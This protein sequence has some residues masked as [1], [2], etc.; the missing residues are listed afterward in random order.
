MATS[1]SL[2]LQAVFKTAADR[3]G[4]DTAARIVSGLSPAAKAF[5]VAA[6]A[7]GRPRDVVVL[8]TPTDRDIDQ[9]VSDVAFF[10]AALEGLSESAASRAVLPFPSHEVD[11]YRGLTPHF[12]V[13]CAR[14]RALQALAKGTGRV[15]VASAAALQ[16]RITS[17]E[18]LTAASVEL[19]PGQDIAPND[20]ADLLVDA[21][22]RREDPADEPGEFALRGGILDVYPPGEPLP[23]RLEFIGDTIETLRTYDP[24]TQRSVQPIDQAGI[25]SLRD[26]LPVER[27][28]AGADDDDLRGE[29]PL[30]RGA[31]LF[32]YLAR[33]HSVRLL[34]SERDEVVAAGEKLAGQMV[35]SQAEAVERNGRAADVNSLFLPWS[36]IADRLAHATELA[37]ISLEDPGQA[38]EP[39]DAQNV[40]HVRCQP[41]VELNGRVP[42]WVA[43]IRKLRDAGETTL[44]VAATPGRAE[45]T[46]E[47][48]KDYDRSEERR[49]GKE[50]RSRWSPYH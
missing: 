29:G 24:A 50:C 21:G 12:G 38:T 49:V 15:L 40:R 41:T 20:L 2:N 14:A 19:K 32:D 6:A 18:R 27:G 44:F 10:L 11:P 9:A 25:V 22:Y 42:D 26:V 7:Q 33:A 28:S 4:L 46:I 47:L 1:T 17:P 31:T 5:Y 37:Q 39:H 48:L 8:V 34:V 13:L 43:E 36:A 35:T 30:D 45:R 16:P 23:V 3:G